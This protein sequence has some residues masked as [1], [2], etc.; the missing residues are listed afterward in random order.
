MDVGEIEGRLVLRRLLGMSVM[1]VSDAYQLLKT[2]QAET[3]VD[4]AEKVILR[5]DD[6][7]VLDESDG[8]RCRD[9]SRSVLLET[10]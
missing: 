1:V 2:G 6:H 7:T 10:R 4:D 9:T 5:C 3:E 8:R